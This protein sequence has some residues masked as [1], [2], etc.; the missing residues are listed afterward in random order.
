MKTKYILKGLIA[1]LLLAFVVAGCESYNEE[2]MESLGNTREFSPLG[3]TTKVKNQTLVELNWTV[4]EAADHYVVEFSADDPEFKTIFKTVQVKGNQLPVSVQLEGETVYAIRVKAIT[5]GLDDSKWTITSATTLSEQILLPIKDVDV[6]GTAVTLR[7]A[8]N[9]NVTQ[10]T[11]TPG[12][13]SHTITPAEKTAGVAVVTG[14]TGETTYTATLLNGTKKRGVATF[15]TGVDLSTGTV[16]NP[17]DDLKAK[18]A[19]APAG[20]KLFL[21]P[22]DYTTASE[23]LLTKPLTIRGAKSYDKP[24]IHGKF[25][26]NTGATSLSLIDLDINGDGVQS[27]VVKYNEISEAYGAL[28]ISGCNIH[29]FTKSLIS[30]SG[31]GSTK[32]VSAIIDN[33][34]V[35][36]ILT[37]G[38]DFIDFRTSHL[39]SLTLKNSTFNNCSVGRDFIRIDAAPGLSGGSLTTNVLIDACTISNKEMKA[40]NRILYVR[41]VNNASTVRNTIFETPLAMY[42]NQAGTTAPTFINNNYFNS[43]ALHTAGDEKVKFDNSGTYGTLDPEFASSATGDFTVKN[44]VVIDKKV[45]D[46]R[47]IK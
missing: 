22:G 19:Q 2:L 40:T 46:P 18:I 21:M 23:F 43:A 47:W 12:N 3:V 37:S 7:W 41:F 4:N 39:G 24:K 10:I 1:T 32:I 35:T 33:S 25:L 31:T 16:I 6:E 29:D 11:M 8:P 15:T 20:S 9:S 36:N 27:D 26:L 42:T 44:Q 28:L 5:K 17:T 14:L 45:G 38:G 34:I 13:I 30:Q